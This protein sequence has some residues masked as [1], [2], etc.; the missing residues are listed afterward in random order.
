MFSRRYLAL[1]CACVLLAASLTLAA[2]RHLSWLWAIV[3]LALVALGLFDLL[4]KRHAIL[5]NYPLW[6]H[7]RF[8]FEF[9]RP[10]IRQ[11]FVED[12]T[13]EKPFSR[14]QRSIVYQRSKNEVD[15]RPYGTELD[16]KAVAHEWISHSLAPT[17]LNGH[18][19]RII[20]GPD[21]PQPYSLSIFNVSAMSF[22][23]LSANAIMALNLGAKKGN[24]AHDT[25]EGSM[26][27]YHRKH[28]GDIIWEIA[29]GY[30]GCR[31]DDG[32]FNPDKFAKQALE[33]QVK[34][35]EIKLSQGAKPGHGGVLPA[36]KI[37][38]E[39][40]ETRGVPMGRD[41]ISPATHSEFSTPRG[42]LE[43]VERLRQ[44]SGGKPTGFKLCIGHPWEFFGIAKA[45]LE[46]GI[47]PDFIV[48]DGAE[49]GTGAA[50]L[51]FTDHVGVP[52]QEGLL[53]VHNTLVGIGLRSKIRIGASGKMI[54][55]FDIAKTLAIGADWVNAARGFMFAVGCIQAQTCHTGRCPT[56]V[57][58]QDEVRQ[59]ALNVPDKSDRVFSFHHNTLRALQEIVQAAGL[60]HP[61][62]L[63]AHHIVRRVSSHEVRLMSELLK[64]LE[65]G[66]LLAGKYHYTLYEKWWPLAR[67]DSFAA[68]GV[69]EA[70]P[71]R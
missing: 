49:G 59:R 16:V 23:S 46:T 65:P 56:G 1:W 21:R 31:N 32:T 25:G 39:I 6:G 57:A 60:R 22:G 19:F 43:F 69:D 26:S 71:A 15:S 5:R 68:L 63:R 51:E 18:D 30:F 37:T 7:L 3:P 36:A 54:T 61:G 52:L 40:A 53:L 13:D 48:V 8:L 28:G 45:M 35:I 55:A 62:D 12:D 70:V 33:P 24:F 14:V 2:T 50:P 42:L 44:L 20:V 64:Y 29:S 66:D 11:Y 4:Q 67:S 41:C 47:L 9:I 34:M 27:K 58:T 10:E 38:A 17:R